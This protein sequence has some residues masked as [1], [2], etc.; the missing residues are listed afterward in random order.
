MPAILVGALR[1][2]SQTPTE[3]SPPVE[4][5]QEIVEKKC[6]AQPISE[7]RTYQFREVPTPTGKKGAYGKKPWYSALQKVFPFLGSPKDKYSVDDIQLIS[8]VYG[9]PAPLGESKRSKQIRLTAEEK[10]REAQR[11]GE[12]KWQEWLKLNPEAGIEERN[13]AEIRLRFQGLAAARLPRF[14]WREYGLD[15]GEV[16]FQGWECNTCWAFA[17]VDA[18]QISRRLAAIRSQK[19]DFDES[20]RPSVRQ[21]VSCMIPKP[22]DYCRTN[23]HGD[24]FTFMVDKGMP[25]GGASKYGVEKFDWKCEPETYVK[26]LTWDYVSSGPTE[27][28]PT[29]DLKRA[30]ITYGPIVSLIKLDDCITLYGN[31]V[32]NEEQKNGGRH[33]I[34]II[35][36]DDSKS[37]WLIKNSYGTN[38][39]EGG[40]GWVKYGSNKIGEASAW[41]IPDP[42]EEERISK[43]FGQEEK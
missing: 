5:Y 14:D 4:S 13:A 12:A 39:G 43:E 7:N 40:F 25:L 34:L 24:V 31:G 26:A 32:F 35:G 18:M 3:N 11:Q 27:I 15:V 6:Q 38:W 22:D 41:I 28:T 8:D 17:A 23:W 29:E 33:I 16:G 37:T 20:L 9:K 2:N 42:K 21:L 10:L 19:N 30:I 1:I 36:W